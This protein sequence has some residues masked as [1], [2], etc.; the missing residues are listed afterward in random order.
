[1]DN[2]N[3]RVTRLEEFTSIMP[4]EVMQ[5][6]KNLKEKFQSANIDQITNI[7][8]YVKENIPQVHSLEIINPTNGNSLIVEYGI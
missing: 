8:E 3:I 5:A 7:V 4:M 1:V 2:I 6:F